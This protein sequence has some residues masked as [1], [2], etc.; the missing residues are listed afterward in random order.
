M[1]IAGIRVIT[2]FC[3]MHI[4]E[5]IMTTALELFNE[6]GT[7]SIT[8]NHIAKE[9]GI[10][11]GNLYYHFPNK[12]AIIR[13][14]FQRAI[15]FMDNTWTIAPKDQI[16]FSRPERMLVQL[17]ELQYVFRFFYLEIFSLLRRDKEL[18]T[19][20]TQI[21]EKRKK[22]IRQFIQWHIDNGIL[23]EELSDESLYS[24]VELSWFIGSYWLAHCVISENV[25]EKKQIKKGVLLVFELFKPYLSKAGLKEFQS[26]QAKWKDV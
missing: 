5:K 12:E 20:Y 16:P 24:L 1:V 15:D 19:M 11:P 3:I 17:F 9:A 25:F 21:Q 22:E 2:L 18:E 13:A 8:T 26:F 10:S 6:H 23:K 7:K 14:I 4:K